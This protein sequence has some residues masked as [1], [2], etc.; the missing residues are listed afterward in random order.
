MYSAMVSADALLQRGYHVTRPLT[1]RQDGCFFR[2]ILEAPR[3]RRYARGMS[4][5]DTVELFELRYTKAQLFEAP[6]EERLFYVMA[7]GLA[8]DI[9][10]L[11]RQ[12]IIAI[13]Q[14]HDDEATKQ[15]SSAIAMLNL[16]LLA[17]RFHEG[18]VLIENRWPGL[19]P[20]YEDHISREGLEA[21]SDLHMHFAG[22]RADNIVFMI[23]NKIGFHAD[24]G[25]A[26][27]MFDDMDD[28][29]TMVEYFGYSFGDTLF[30]GSEVTHY[31]AL[32]RFTKEDDDFEAFGA[33]MDELRILQRHFLTFINAYVKVFVSRHLVRSPS[34]LRKNRRMLRNLPAFET[35]RIPFFADFSARP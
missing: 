6:E 33:V 3:L 10:I 32:R 9:Q 19:S 30:A 28:D 2:Q 4:D 22:A 34:E 27:K 18:W 16:R 21:V 14:G 1:S 20:S 5:R 24:Y 11:L 31:A 35:M 7:T 8:N 17:G 29:L 25:F 26:R 13:K 23:R 15:A 12:Y